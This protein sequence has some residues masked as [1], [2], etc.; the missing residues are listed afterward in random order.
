ML[1]RLKKGSIIK[2]EFIEIWNSPILRV[3]R[4]L[5]GIKDV[6]KDKLFKGGLEENRNTRSFLWNNALSLMHIRLK[7]LPYNLR[8][9]FHES[10]QGQLIL[11]NANKRKPI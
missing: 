2:K 11:K 7:P 5:C 4:V 3:L 9:F 6:G 8:F 10:L 1:L